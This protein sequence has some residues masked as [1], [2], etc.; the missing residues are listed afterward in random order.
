MKSRLIHIGT[1]A[2]YLMVVLALLG[3]LPAKSNEVI[4]AC[5]R[6]EPEPEP[7]DR[8]RPYRVENLTTKDSAG[9]VIN[10]SDLYSVY[11]GQRV[12]MGAHVLT[13]CALPARDPAQ[14]EALDLLGFTSQDFE[15][16]LKQ[17]EARLVLVP[18][19]N[20]M[21]KCMVENHPSIGFFMTAFENER[22]GPC[23]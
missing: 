1:H 10:L 13:A 9:I 16:A 19:I 12:Q 11:G 18:S 4:W 23:F 17:P 20:R 22:V 15:Q 7:F 14:V 5:S 8:L 21:Q 6:S 2:R 3:A